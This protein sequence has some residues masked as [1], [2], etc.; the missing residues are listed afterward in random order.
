MGGSAPRGQGVVGANHRQVLWLEPG[1]SVFHV[2]V[3]EILVSLR[4]VQDALDQ[5]DN[6]TD[7][8]GYDENGQHDVH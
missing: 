8:C 3:L 2:G 4:Q 5:T 6:G 1:F 7:G